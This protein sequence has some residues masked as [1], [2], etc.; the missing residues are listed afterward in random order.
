MAEIAEIISKFGASA[1]G[2]LANA[3]VTGAP[4]DQLRA[5]LFLRSRLC[6][7]TIFRSNCLSVHTD[8]SWTDSCVRDGTLGGSR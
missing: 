3:A 4:E 7:C 8:A 6:N 1:K 5:P 2:K